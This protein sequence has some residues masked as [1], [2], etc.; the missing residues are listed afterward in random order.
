M[1]TTLA[2]LL[3]GC[4][5]LKK[6]DA[7]FLQGDSVSGTPLGD[8]NEGVNFLGGNINK[9]MFEPI[10]FQYDSFEIAPAEAAKLDRVAEFLR[11]NRAELIVAGF[12]DERGTT[13]YNRALGEKRALA[14][15]EFVIQRGASGGR[16]QTVSF[17]EEMPA[18]AGGGE[19]AWAA[20]RRAEFGVVQ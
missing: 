1:L 18:D 10:Y 2:L 19:S 9:G 8:R 11:S 20:N 16:L 6:N 7:D 13:E 14:V 15:R 5:N 4:Q 17:G 12:T 3:T